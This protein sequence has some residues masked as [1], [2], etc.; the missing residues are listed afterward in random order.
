MTEGDT[1]EV[2]NQPPMLETLAVNLLD[3][4]PALQAAVRREGG[5]WGEARLKEYGAL[6]GGEL[7][8]LGFDANRNPPVLRSHDRQGRRLDRVDYHPAY[9]RLMSVAMEHELHALTW[10]EPRDG[11]QVVRSA[12]MY[13]HGQA[14]AGTL[15]P[16]TMTHACLPSL[17]L[18]SELAATWEPRV[19]APVYDPTFGPAAGKRSATVGMA[20]TEKQG[21]SDVRANTT[22]AR[23]VDDA[24]GEYALRGHKWF[25][26]APM[27]DAFLVLAQAPA[28]L[29]CFLMPRFLPDGRR[30][31]I[32]IQRLKD[33]LGNRSNASAEIELRD[34]RGWRIGEEGRGVPSIIEMV[35]Q[36]RVDCAI[37]SAALMR[38]ALVQAAHH[39]RY[40]EAFGQAL[41]RQPLMRA[42][43]AD[44]ALES[45]AAMALALRVARAVEAGRRGDPGARRF[46]RLVN[47]IAKYWVCKRAP[48][49]IYEA[50]ECLGGNGYV[51]ESLLPRL[52][53]EA[54]VNAIWEGSGNVQ[55]LDVLRAVEREPQA[56]AEV[57][58]QIGAAAHGDARLRQYLGRLK[59][60]MERDR[61]NPARARRLVER[62][63]VALQ[64]ALLL[65]GSPAP[66]ADAFCQSRLGDDSGWLFGTLPDG[67]D[68]KAIVERAF[69]PVAG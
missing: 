31:A 11:S 18:Q 15:C 42:V 56:L 52:Y 48:G 40:R 12:L 4:D 45:E 49:M 46:A 5:D 66:V 25:C 39:C 9:H 30:N 28:G 68:L 35:V 44:L 34:A 51:E 27:S 61:Q 65:E 63:A 26:S 50:Q 57:F 3:T 55:C 62:L 19:C 2:G 13:L 47:P 17:R 38:Q 64:A 6:A 60:D 33:K 43:L 54:P 29:S 21:G 1:H 23:P 24:A 16:L 8:E 53:R 41:G 59:H 36:T 22:V 7:M 14:E 67:L 20:M 37:G 69:P 10:R 32:E 58:D